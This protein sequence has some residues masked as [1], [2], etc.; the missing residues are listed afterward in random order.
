MNSEP[1][2]IDNRKQ[3]KNELAVVDLGGKPTGVMP[4]PEYIIKEVSDRLLAQTVLTHQKRVRVRRAHTK[5]RAEVRGGGRKPWKQKGTGN[6]RHGSIRSPI[7]VGGG[8]TF[9]PRSRKTRVLPVPTAM[10]RRAFAGVL[11]NLA[12][13]DRLAVVEIN[14]DLPV[15]TNEIKEKLPADCRG[16]LILT[17]AGES[18]SLARATRNLPAIKVMPVAQATVSDLMVARKVWLARTALPEVERRCGKSSVEIK[19]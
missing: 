9:G 2:K 8:I 17:A 13:A 6:S 4:W 5:G 10:K 19:A 11:Y 7:W 15:K 18:G 3:T 1:K 14:K 12:Q 16:L